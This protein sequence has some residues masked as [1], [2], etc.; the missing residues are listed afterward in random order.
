MGTVGG[1][2]FPIIIRPLKMEPWGIE[3][4]S[5]VICLTVWIRQTVRMGFIQGRSLLDG[6]REVGPFHPCGF[7]IHTVVAVQSLPHSIL[8]RHA[9]EG[10]LCD[11][12]AHPGTRGHSGQSCQDR[13]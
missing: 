10:F 11:R 7:V 3:G 6:V 2:L 9:C 13:P 12:V 1:I 5:P 8:Q 4:V